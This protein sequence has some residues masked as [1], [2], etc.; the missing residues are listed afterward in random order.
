MDWVSYTEWNGGAA[1]SVVGTVMVYPEL[2]SPQLGNQ[3]HILVYL[4]PSYETRGTDYPVVYMHDGQNLFDKHTSGHGEWCADE[5]MEALA[6]EGI[7]AILV[8]IPHRGE[9]RVH[10]LSPYVCPQSGSLGL[11]AQYTGFIANEVKRLIDRSFR[12][13]RGPSHTGIMGSSMGGLIS[14]HACLREPE[15]FGLCGAMSPAL[16]FGNYAILDEVRTARHFPIRLYMDSGR[17]EI[18]TARRSASLS[19]RAY[20]RRAQ[21]LC[22]ESPPFESSRLSALWVEDVRSLH[23]LLETYAKRQTQLM[24]VETP[25]EHNEAAWSRRFPDAIRFLLEQTL[26]G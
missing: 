5:T 20:A 9:Q 16:W 11:G 17:S 26:D 8:G 15:T 24:Y 22:G 6:A 1:H 3:R 14:L 25:S 18:G 19:T 10:E 4:P 23:Q 21:D 7:E 2:A 13:L 12:T